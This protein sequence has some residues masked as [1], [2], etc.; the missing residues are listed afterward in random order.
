MYSAVGAQLM[1]AVWLCCVGEGQ[2]IHAFAR[3]STSPRHR[4][5]LH[6]PPLPVCTLQYRRQVCWRVWQR[7]SVL[8]SRAGSGWCVVRWS[9]ASVTLCLS[10]GFS[11][12]PQ[13]ERKTAWAIGA[14]LSWHTVHGSHTACIDPGG[15]R[16]KVKVNIV[17]TCASSMG[18]V[19]HAYW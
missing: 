2:E 15:K 1:I 5:Q 13:S 11:E 7:Y 17:V 6:G 14:K 10:V 4:S 18:S 8:V 9:M 19:G 16:S 3:Q 12:C